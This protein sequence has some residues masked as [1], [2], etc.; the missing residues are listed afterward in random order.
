MF[1]IRTS[2]R[3]SLKENMV[4]INKPKPLT[5]ADH[6]RRHHQ[7]P[8]IVIIPNHPITVDSSN[9]L[10]CVC[11]NNLE[12]G[13]I[14]LALKCGANHVMCEE[15]TNSNFITECPVCKM[16]VTTTSVIVS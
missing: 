11:S 15:C 3:R 2:Q 5:M 8:S 4:F 14:A 6:G 9:I 1:R 16:P 10:C 7:I 13:S 12:S